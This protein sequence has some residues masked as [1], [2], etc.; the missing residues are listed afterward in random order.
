MG[1]VLKVRFRHIHT[2][3]TLFT[4]VITLGRPTIVWRSSVLL[5]N[6]FYHTNSHLRDAKAATRKISGWVL[7]VARRIELGISLIFLLIFARGQFGVDRSPTLRTKDRKMLFPVK[8]AQFL[9]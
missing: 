3:H 8:M 5:L 7:C 4:V 2:L 6:F 9:H 1:I